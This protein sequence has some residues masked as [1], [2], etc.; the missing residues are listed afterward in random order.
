MN[1]FTAK[2]PRRQGEPEY[3][4]APTP[5]KDL[6]LF[7]DA[8]N[9]VCLSWRLGVLAVK[10]FKASLV[11]LLVFIL[12]LS[13]GLVSRALA[14]D[15]KDSAEDGEVAAIQQLAQ[16]GYLGDKKDFYLSAKSLAEDDV[17]DALIKVNAQLETVDVKAIPPGKSP[18]QAGDLQVLLKL[19]KD[20]AED[21][22]A[23]KVSA[24]K[25]QKKVE[26]LLAL[27]NAPAGDAK[28]AAPASTPAPPGETAKPAPADTP[29]PAVSREEWTQ[30]KSDLQDL[31][32][33]TNDMRDAYDKKIDALQ[34][35]DLDSK[36]ALAD[37]KTANE[38]IRA[39]NTDL[40]TSDAE[41]KASN[42]DNLEQLKL[43]KKLLDRVQDDLKLSNDH[44]EQ[45]AKK[46]AEKTMT[47]TELQQELQVMHKDLRDNS[48]DVS[49]L[50]QEVAKLDKTDSQS[51]QN[52]LDEFLGSKWLAGGA[53]VVG[54][55][56]LIISVTR[57]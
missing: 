44:I 32:R 39:A 25:L 12:A 46:A 38:A 41:L 24:W 20:K 22:R 19:V 49:I 3:D 2:T 37:V 57:K 36:T 16:H 42:A 47:D 18:Y 28:A 21:I 45:V 23:R 52:P 53:L 9:G 26:K 5:K 33:K 54:V 29:V 34:K 7:R 30:L 10:N 17:T 6:T 15:D 31:T 11:F 27:A 13:P 4:P 55:T 35:S 8:S 1:R 43:V 48:Q 50:K 14:Q 40:K 56:A 51:N